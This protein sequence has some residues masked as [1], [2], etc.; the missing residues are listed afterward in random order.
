M[1]LLGLLVFSVCPLFA[2]DPVAKLQVLPQSIDFGEVEAYSTEVATEDIIISNCGDPDSVLCW[3]ITSNDCWI[4]VVGDTIQGEINLPDGDERYEY[5]TMC[6][7]GLC[8]DEVEHEGIVGLYEGAFRVHQ[9]DYDYSATEPECKWGVVDPDADPEFIEIEATMTISEFNVLEVYTDDPDNPHKLDFG[10]DDDEKELYI[11]NAG[12]GEMEWE[13]VV[14]EDIGWLTVEDG[15]STSDTNI[16]GEVKEVTVEVDRSKVEGCAEDHIASIM[17]SSTNALPD[18]VT[19]SVFMQ[20]DIQPPQP[21]SPTPADGS[22]EQSLY[23]TLKWEVGGEDIGGIFYFDVYF[24]DNQT[25]VDNCSPSVLACEELE[26]AYCEPSKREW[27]LYVNTTY[28][29]KVRAVDECEGNTVDSET[30]NFTTGSQPDRCLASMVLQLNDEERNLLRRFRDEVL[31]RS[32]DGE[33]Y[34]NLYYSPYAIEAFFI[35]LFN[36][37]LRVCANR[38]VKESLSA[39]QSMLRGGRALIDAEIIADVELFLEEFGKEASPGLKKAIS[40]IK[41]D[42]AIGDLFKDFGF[43]VIK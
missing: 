35:L 3:G 11:K 17:V 7:S 16:T 9:Y 19:V 29:W 37:E 31:V 43:S 42:I 12:E 24:S 1:V 32:L 4:C 20:R 5:V 23:T 21:S 38:I 26:D 6:A 2:A 13:A 28:Y 14:S 39:I 25:L 10:T 30:W 34:I 33:R 40:I 27:P 8:I 18:E 22:A 15:T 36:P 41:R